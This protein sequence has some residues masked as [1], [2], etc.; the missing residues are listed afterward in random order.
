M[1]EISFPAGFRIEPNQYLAGVPAPNITKPLGALEIFNGSFTG[2]GLNAIF[3]PNNGPPNTTNFPND[4]ILELN[5]VNDTTTF[6]QPFG[7]VPNRGFASQNDIFLNGVS[8]MQ[9]INDVTNVGTGRADGLPTG[10]HFEPGLWMY[11]PATNDTPVLGDTLVR[12]ASIP[13]GTT[14]NAQCL[15]PTTS[16]A[17]PP[18][19]PPGNLAPFPV[20]GGDLLKLD[21][22]NASSPSDLRLPHDLSKFI[23]AGTI[24]QDIL[25]DPN[26]VLRNSIEGQTIINTTTFTVSTSASPPV[27]G[28]GTANIAFLEGDPGAKAPNANAIQM[29]ATF[30]IETVQYEL[31]VPC[32]KPGQAPMKISPSSRS[33]Q[34]RPEFLVSPPH[35]ITEPTTITVTSVQIQYSQIVFLVFDN[36]IW[37]HVSVATLNPLEPVIVSDSAWD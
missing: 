37:P 28:G 3:R 26:T 25:N 23:A 8:Y 34:A 35:E 24:T 1:A 11:A 15:V 4:N 13:H 6:T 30:W 27:F 33:D 2:L 29:N 21:S 17:G 14:I 20:D 5:L 36:L 22:L 12:M 7:A 9:F 19:I 16:S 32:F 31:E 10:I 18:Q